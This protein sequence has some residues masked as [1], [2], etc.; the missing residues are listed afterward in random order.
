MKISAYHYAKALY[1]ATR[2]KERDEVD[3][4]VAGFSNLLIKNNHVRLISEIIIKFEAIWNREKNITKAEIISKNELEGEAVEKIK[5]FLK[6]KYHARE[7][8]LRRK[9]DENILGGIIVKAG[10]EMWDGS[11]RRQLEE[12]KEVL[13]R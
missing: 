8:V 4:C 1:E 5:A 11:V 6:S 3:Q 7:V 9:V 12:L 10:D 13:V 2:E